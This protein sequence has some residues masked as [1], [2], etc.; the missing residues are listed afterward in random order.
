MYLKKKK[1]KKTKFYGIFL[2]AIVPT[3][4]CKNNSKTLL[5]FYIV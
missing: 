5:T 4:S 3:K 1:K 2:T